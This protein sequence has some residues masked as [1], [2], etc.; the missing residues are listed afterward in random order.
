[1]K[2]NG[3]HGEIFLKNAWL[4][5]VILLVSLSGDCF[6]STSKGEKALKAGDYLTALHVFSPLAEKGDGTAQYNLG[7]MYINGQGVRQD[8]TQAALWFR[9]AADQGHA[10]AQGILAFLYINGQ[11]VRQDYTQ[12]ALW[13]RKAA[14]QGD[15]YAH[16]LSASCMRRA[17]VDRRTTRRPWSGTA[18]PPTK[19]TSLAN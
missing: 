11:G 18:K 4:T 7:G 16:P 15:A 8:Y 14:D 3:H 5:L 1:M 19:A 12:A 9:K 10:G 13:L 17:K 2:L 6:A